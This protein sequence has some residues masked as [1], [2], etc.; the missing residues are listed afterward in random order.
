LENFV[1]LFLGNVHSVYYKAFVKVK[2]KL[3]KSFRALMD[4]A[5][6]NECTRNKKKS[7][8]KGGRSCKRGMCDA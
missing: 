8:Q 5:K 6:Q 3:K 7:L 4:L 2:L 1:V